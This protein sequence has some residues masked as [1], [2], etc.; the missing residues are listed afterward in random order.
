V[1]GLCEPDAAK[2]G[3]V[4]AQVEPER[5]RADALRWTVRQV[6]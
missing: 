6:A 2:A 1:C 5:E 4:R 3:W